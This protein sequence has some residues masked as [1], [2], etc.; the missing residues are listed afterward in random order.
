M[1]GLLKRVSMGWWLLRLTVNNL[2]F[3]RL[4]VNFFPSQLTEVLKVNFNCFN[5]LKLDFHCCKKLKVNFHCC[6]TYFKVQ[7]PFW[8]EKVI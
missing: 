5:K 6:K 8:D 1:K 2:A 4:T 3:L 7:G